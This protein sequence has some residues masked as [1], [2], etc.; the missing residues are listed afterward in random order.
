ML[1]FREQWRI[2]KYTYRELAFYSLAMQHGVAAGD[3]KT[4]ERLLRNAQ[5]VYILKLIVGVFALIFGVGAIFLLKDSIVRGLTYASI[6]NASFAFASFVIYTGFIVFFM[7]IFQASALGSIDLFLPLTSLSLSNR[8]ISKVIYLT[9]F[10]IFDLVVLVPLL[11]Y[12]VLLQIFLG[13][14][15][16]TVLQT[17]SMAVF[18]FFMINIVLYVSYKYM[19]GFMKPEV[20]KVKIVAK[21]VLLVTYTLVFSTVYVVP[22]VLQ[23]FL[24]TITKSIINLPK[25][26][27]ELIIAVPPISL[28][29]FATSTG[30]LTITDSLTYLISATSTL[31]FTALT[32][33]TFKKVFTGVT[34]YILAGTP[35]EKMESRRVRRV[36]I[37]V[38]KHLT[39]AIVKRDLKMMMRQPNYAV[40]LFF[41]PI[42]LL[43]YGILFFFEG[44]PISYVENM[45]YFIVMLIVMMSSSVIFV[46]DKGIL[47]TLSLPIRRK[48]LIIGKA[49]IMTL[50]Y[51]V[52][53]IGIAVLDLLTGQFGPKTLVLIPLIMGVFNAEY[54]AIKKGME[55]VLDKGESLMA[56]KSDL[57]YIIYLVLLSI[58]YFEIP[59]GLMVAL[60]YFPTLS[61]QLLVLETAIL[62]VYAIELIFNL[63]KGG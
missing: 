18:V 21:L 10:R 30:T 1:K 39:L 46:E 61:L 41:G 25:V 4:V 57:G 56:L 15:L 55:M 16:L 17:L 23:N 32:A 2:S 24:P 45:I 12:A 27:L 9:V 13:N 28:A 7:T 44:L 6:F 63:S 48:N 43:V 59:Y 19:R 50:T 38:T 34:N 53:V 31:I 35:L 42:M 29:Y 54:R 8:D 37:S 58:I 11:G 62:A 20:S 3:K 51:V 14:I 40:L 33:L 60:G 5:N 22:I 52:S 47:F 26:Y 36:K 49:F